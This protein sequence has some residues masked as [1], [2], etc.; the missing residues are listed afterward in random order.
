MMRAAKTVA[1]A[2]AVLALAACD[3]VGDGSKPEALSIVKNGFP[4][5]PAKAFTCTREQL[6]LAG[7]FTSGEL[8]E[9]SSR[10]RWTSNNSSV[11]RVSNGDIP[12]PGEDGLFFAR[13]QLI[14]VAPGTATITASAFGLSESLEIEVDDPGEIFVSA[15]GYADEEA[16]K[17][18]VNIARTTRQQL[19]VTALI[20]GHPQDITASAELEF[21]TP[22]DTI[23][24]FVK[25]S[26][27]NNTNVIQASANKDGTLTVRAKF[28][29]CDLPEPPKLDISV[30]QPND[31]LVLRREIK[32]DTRSKF[33]V[34]TSEIFRVYASF[35]SDGLAEQDLS[36]QLLVTS[37]APAVIL[38]GAF[39]IASAV[40]A[41][42]T[43]EGTPAP[44]ESAPLKLTFCIPVPPP[45]PLPDDYEASCA[46]PKVELDGLTALSDQLQSFTI[47]TSDNQGVPLTAADADVSLAPLATVQFRAKGTF[48]SGFQQDVTRNMVWESSLPA[49]VT[50]N[51]TSGIARSNR[52]QPPQGEDTDG[53]GT[54]DG[55]APV[56]KIS[57]TNN[58]ETVTT[59]EK[60]VT[61]TI[62]NP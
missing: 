13:G 23:A 1:A 41:L 25:D 57:A 51:A 18:A 19:S 4:A 31:T 43:G 40:R 39:G 24:T 12:V 49:E 35:N 29:T 2:A 32:D 11:L 5:S 10:A 50:I 21:E 37:S 8:G 46:T 44:T 28:L 55:P 62:T 53:D 20:D 58:S 34:G 22:D 45:D 60:E 54:P 3:G 15:A 36:T 9:F 48:V 30:K 16:A 14:P 26:N 38:P 33:V 17:T 7:R 61:V 6:L 47:I 27:D 52:L 56:I 42:S 59:K